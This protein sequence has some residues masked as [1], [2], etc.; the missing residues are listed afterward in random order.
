M[1]M[2]SFWYVFILKL[3]YITHLFLVFT[4]DVEQSDAC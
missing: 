3:E 1:A 2:T 4:V